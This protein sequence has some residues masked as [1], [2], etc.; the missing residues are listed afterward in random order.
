MCASDLFVNISNLEVGILYSLHNFL[1]KVFDPSSLAA[2][3]LG[4]NIFI[5]VL[6]KKSDIPSTS[7]FSGPTT[8]NFIFFFQTLF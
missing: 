3:L 2:I 4:P 8:N 1:V 5:L 6:L 7:G